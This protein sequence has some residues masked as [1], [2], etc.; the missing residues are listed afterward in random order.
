MRLGKGAGRPRKSDEEKKKNKRHTYFSDEELALIEARAGG[1]PV[2]QYLRQ[3]ALEPRLDFESMPLVQVPFFGSWEEA[4]GKAGL[5]PVPIW[6]QDGLRLGSRGVVA[7]LET[8]DSESR[9]KARVLAFFTLQPFMYLPQ[10]EEFGLFEVETS[11]GGMII[12]YSTFGDIA[13]SGSEFRAVALMRGALLGPSQVVP[14]Y[15]YE[16]PSL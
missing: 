12:T 7:S 1:A 16:S 14:R 4:L 5:L 13:S 15:S 10:D 9:H 11:D 8:S 6:M 3:S 2:S